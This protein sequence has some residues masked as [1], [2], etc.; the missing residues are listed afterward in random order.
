MKVTLKVFRG[1]RGNGKV[2]WA[3]FA[4][5]DLRIQGEGS[6]RKITIRPNA[7]PRWLPKPSGEEC[8]I[9]RN[10]GTRI[11]GE[12]WVDLPAGSILRAGAECAGGYRRA[13]IASPPLI[14]EEGAL[15]REEEHDGL[16]WV[17]LRVENA[18]PLSLEEAEA[19]QRRDHEDENQDH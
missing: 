10:L 7:T 4:P 11:D 1:G 18:R 12:A 6:G 13:Y 2:W 8:R 9:S 5:A 19:M 14:V 16:R 15:Y 3:Q 17:D